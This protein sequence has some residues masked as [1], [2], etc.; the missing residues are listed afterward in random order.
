MYDTVFTLFKAVQNT[1]NNCIWVRRV[2]NHSCKV[3][4][5]DQ[6]EL[7]IS[8]RSHANWS[9]A[10]A[11]PEN[12]ESKVFLC[13]GNPAKYNGSLIVESTAELLEWYDPLCK[14]TFDSVRKSY[15]VDL[16]SQNNRGF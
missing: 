15:N 2:S 3:N 16:F 7:C 6:T 8:Y 10:K 11:R 1:F 5:F 14:D 4:Y 13:N 9:A 12:F